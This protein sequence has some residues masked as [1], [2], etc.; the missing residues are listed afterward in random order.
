VSRSDVRIQ[1]L[2]VPDCALLA[3]AR[4]LVDEAVLATGV[5]RA[6]VECVMG[7]YP[8]PTV[9]VNGID[10]TGRGCA[11]GAA[12]RLGLPTGDQVRIALRQAAGSAEVKL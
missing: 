12:C 1:I 10:V 4:E 6:T 3:R 8:S 7:D 11:P 5:T 2:H 9:L